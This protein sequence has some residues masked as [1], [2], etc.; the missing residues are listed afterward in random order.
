MRKTVAYLQQGIVGYEK[1]QE[2]T[3]SFFEEFVKL[4]FEYNLF[5]SI[6][7]YDEYLKLEYDD[8]M[9]LPP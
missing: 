5:M 3:F 8:Y 2:I 6:A 7:K 4:E 1:A 9:Q